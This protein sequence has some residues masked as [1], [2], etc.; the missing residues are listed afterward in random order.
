MNSGS[1]TGS[2]R[3][4]LPQMI[5]ALCSATGMTPSMLYHAIGRSIG[6]QVEAEP[7]AVGGRTQPDDSKAEALKAVKVMESRGEAVGESSLC[8]VVATACTQS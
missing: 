7:Q 5:S 4:D 1:P 2:N 6:P 3:A 8:P